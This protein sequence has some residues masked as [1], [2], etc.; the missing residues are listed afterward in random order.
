MIKA[1][2][3]GSMEGA[4]AWQRWEYANN[5]YRADLM[6]LKDS[7]GFTAADVDESLRRA[8]AVPAALAARAAA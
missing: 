8:A 3:S 6:A 5:V 2:D 7:F 4:I 1:R